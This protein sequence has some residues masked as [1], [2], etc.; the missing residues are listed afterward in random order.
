MKLSLRFFFTKIAKKYP[1]T[2]LS[3]YTD[4]APNFSSLGILTKDMEL[5]EEVLYVD[6]LTIPQEDL[7]SNASVITTQDRSSLFAQCNLIVVPYG[8]DL[9]AIT[10][11]VSHTFTHYFGWADTI[12]EAIAQNRGLDT[13]VNLTANIVQNPLYIADSSFKMLA[14]WGGDFM[15]INPTWRYQEKYRYLPYQV[16]QNLIES[17][18]LEKLYNTPHAWKIDNSK[19]FSALP[20]I[21][22]AIRMDGVHYGNFYIIELY[23]LLDDCDLEIADYLGTVLSTA[24][25][26]NLN[27]L[28]TSTL[29]HAHFLADIIEGTLTDRQIMLDQLRALHWDIE[30]DYLVGLI[31]SAEDNDAIR[32]HMMALLNSDLGAQCLYY[33][34]NVLAI[35]NNA[36]RDYKRI[37]TRLQQVGRDFNRTVAVSECFSDFSEISKYYQQAHYALEYSDPVTDKGHTLFYD[38]VSLD[39]LITACKEDIAPYAPADKLV[40]YDKEHHTEYAHTLL[41]WLMLERNGIK[42]AKDLYIHRNTLGNRLAHIADITGVNLD[43][44][45]VRTRMLI[46]LYAIKAE[47]QRMS[48]DTQKNA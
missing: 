15:E 10:Q 12:Y 25:Y 40:S 6:L 46:A 43:D 33:Q 18:E 7:P 31:G 48:V 39:H 5:S 26:G 24:L 29:Y 3:S 16:M 22:K 2:M 35:I 27:Y 32:H 34:D 14:S 1:G 21:S 38:A 45:F 36:S 19:G 37:T 23:D 4:T 17:E 41:T 44:F 28:R 11:L 8:V 30:G 42:A 13:I 20:F 47:E 9:A